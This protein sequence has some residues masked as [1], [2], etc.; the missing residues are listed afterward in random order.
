MWLA[1]L[2][3]LGTFV[4]LL[5]VRCQCHFSILSLFLVCHV[6]A[7]LCYRDVVSFSFPSEV[8]LLMYL[9]SWL[10][11][12]WCSFPHS[13]FAYSSWKDFCPF[14]THKPSSMRWGP[15]V[16]QYSLHQL[17]PYFFSTMCRDMLAD[18]P[19][20]SPFLELLTQS[21]WA[22]S[23]GAWLVCSTKEQGHPGPY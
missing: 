15:K 3:A 1:H 7:F 2:E 10:T 16:S 20:E 17:S 9:Y 6:V 19:W 21:N 18:V 11:L 14:S 5:E 12:R 4:G 8:P 23:V 22:G 13:N